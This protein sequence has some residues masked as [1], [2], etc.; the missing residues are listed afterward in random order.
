MSTMTADKRRWAHVLVFA[1]LSALLVPLLMMAFASPASADGEGDRDNYSLYQLAS[2]ASTFFS[3]ENSPAGDELSDDWKAV[4]SSPATGGSLLGYADPEF[5]MGD[6]TGWF[7]AEVSGSSQTIRYETLKSEGDNGNV[8]SGMLD[9]AHFGAANAD[10]GL[11][12]MSSGVGGQIAN[13]ISG[14]VIWLLYA[15]SLAVS[16]VFSLVI[17][18]LQLINPFLWFGNAVSEINKT[19]GQGMTRGEEAPAALKGL[20]NFISDWYGLINSIAWE[21]LVPL[22]IGFLLIGLVL[23]KKMDRGSAIKKLVVRLVF[24]GVGLPLIGSMYTGVLDKF[25]DLGGQSGGPT[26]VVLSTYVDFESWIMNDRLAIPGEASI[27]WRDGQASSES[28]MS[29]R[30][31]ALAINKQSHGSVFEDIEIGTRPDAASTAW[32]EGMVGLGK[33][34]VGDTAMVLTTFGILND[35][36][37]SNEVAAS[38]FE[39]GIKSSITKLDVDDKEDW[40]VNDEGYGDPKA[41]DDPEGPAPTE[42]PVISTHAQEGLTSSTPGGS[43]TTFTTLNSAA[44]CGFIVWEADGPAH[45]NLSPLSAYNYLNTGFDSSSLTMYS[46]NNA[47]SGFTRESHMAVSQ[48]GIGPAKF[49]YWANAATVL[50]CIVLLG[51]WYAIGMLAGSVKR[52]FSLV[53]A[54]PFAT[55]GAVAAISKVVAYSAA[56]ILEVLVTLFLYQFVSEFLISIP[57]IMAGPVSSLVIQ[58]GL[59][60]SAAL[61]GIV[62]VILTLI[63]LLLIIGVTFA[64]LKV[65]KV[66]LQA[67]DEA[68]TKVVD[69]FLE[70]STTSAPTPAKPGGMVPPQ[71]PD[72][73]TGAGMATGQTRGSGIGGSKAPGKNSTSTPKTMSTNAGGTNGSPKALTTGTGT[74]ELGRGGSSDPD[75]SVGSAVGPDARHSGGG[76]GSDVRMRAGGTGPEGLGQDDDPSDNGGPLQLTSDKAGSSRSDKEAAQSLSSRGGLTPLG[77]SSGSQKGSGDARGGQTNF[78]SRGAAASKALAEGGGRD[79]FSSSGTADGSRSTDRTSG[80]RGATVAQSTSMQFDTDDQLGTP[81]TPAAD[82]SAAQARAGAAR[83]SISPD[84]SD[85]P[86]SGRAGIPSPP[87]AHGGAQVRG[88]AGGLVTRSTR[89]TEVQRPQSQV[90]TG[91]RSGEGEPGRIQEGQSTNQETSQTSPAPRPVQGRPQP[92]VARSAS[93]YKAAAQPSAPGVASKRTTS[94]AAPAP[95]PPVPP[96]QSPAAPQTQRP[97]APAQRQQG[98]V[99]MPTASPV[100]K[101]TPAQRAPAPRQSEQQDKQQAP[102]GPKRIAAPAQRPRSDQWKNEKRK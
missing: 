3:Q 39:S 67:M 44:G 32:S 61:G 46:S 43:T 88:T 66:V 65:R 6:I 80:G 91:P 27:G 81:S 23:F 56:L 30:T 63:S 95:R 60:G 45:C 51:L 35:Y 53:A 73:G 90:G 33:E 62:V 89:A 22:F 86:N 82:G 99:P 15:L 68:F 37:T 34:G 76:S 18:L 100:A 10:L 4:T 12:T 54:I 25:D 72:V 40:F 49:M 79:G 93:T 71:A 24:I 13:M 97:Q 98:A 7:F 47:T 1:L 64:L 26:R 77:Y 8:Y 41:Y 21:A 52:T 16:M 102:P 75:G 74:L 55:L 5:S 31:T 57:G 28:L 96:L 70:T 36:I 17:K 101:S 69:K 83:F 38:D 29:V 48:V 58:D 78:G 11:D 14:S 92:P 19:F 59:L 2:N 87:G 85:Q 9:Y 42:H 50:A 84:E 94:A 20:A